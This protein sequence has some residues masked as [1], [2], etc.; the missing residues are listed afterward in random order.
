MTSTTRWQVNGGYG[1]EDPY[2][3]DLSPV[4]RSFSEMGF[5][6]SFYKISPRLWVAI[7]FSGWRTN[8]V[9]LPKGSAFRVEPALM[10]FF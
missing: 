2:N 7:E 3:R 9:D 4:Q 1:R 10:F 6:N 8:W 5:V